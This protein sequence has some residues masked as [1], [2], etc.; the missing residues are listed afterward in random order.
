MPHSFAA[1]EVLIKR[2]IFAFS[3]LFA[4]GKPKMFHVLSQVVNGQTYRIR[5]Q[6]RT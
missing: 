3:P 2:T 5:Y 6:L 1:V 4:H